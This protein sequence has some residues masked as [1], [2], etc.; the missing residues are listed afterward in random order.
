MVGHLPPLADPG[1]GVLRG[2]TPTA[3]KIDEN[4]CFFLEYNENLAIIRKCL[5]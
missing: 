5:F 2:N 1:E 3:L 4:L